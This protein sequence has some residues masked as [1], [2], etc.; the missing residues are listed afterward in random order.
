VC[1]CV[2]LCRCVCVCVCVCDAVVAEYGAT[3]WQILGANFNEYLIICSPG[4]KHVRELKEAISNTHSNMWH[5][6]VYIT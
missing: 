4:V 6:I 1:V 3:F 5:G 2:C